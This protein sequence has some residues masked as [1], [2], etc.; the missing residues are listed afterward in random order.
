[1]P[2]GFWGAA[3]A[4]DTPQLW[5]AGSGRRPCRATAGGFSLRG[6]RK[7]VTQGDIAAWPGTVSQQVAGNLVAGGQGSRQQSKAE[8]VWRRRPSRAP[9]AQ[10]GKMPGEMLSQAGAGRQ[11][12]L[13]GEPGTCWRAS[14]PAAPSPC[15]PHGP[16]PVP[17]VG[18][19]PPG[20]LRWGAG[21]LHVSESCLLCR[22]GRAFI[23]LMSLETLLPG[24][25]S[26][27]H[28]HPAWGERGF[29]ISHP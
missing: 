7:W 4:G 11:G 17:R 25:A 24:R 28:P 22:A 5:G 21:G 27:Q 16:V 2:R 14:S 18:G 6:S 13:Y 9:T 8:Q 26:Q 12:F 19:L 15:S 23:C 3:P 10:G 1:M 29:N 20:W